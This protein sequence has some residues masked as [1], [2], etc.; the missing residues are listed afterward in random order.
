MASQSAEGAGTDASARTPPPG[1]SVQQLQAAQAAQTYGWMQYAGAAYTAAYATQQVVLRQQQQ[2][3][4][5]QQ[6]A[7]WPA[8]AVTNYWGQQQV[9]SQWGQQGLSPAATTWGTYNE[10]GVGAWNAGSSPQAGAAAT[11]CMNGFGV[12]N[13]FGTSAPSELPSYP[14][15]KLFSLDV[16]CVAVGTTHLISDRYPCLLALVDGSSKV[17]LRVTI[18]PDRHVFSYLTPLTGMTAEDMENGVSLE[19][20]TDLLRKH[21]PSD[22]VLVGQKPDG[23][24]EWMKLRKGV[25]FGEVID[26]AEVLKGFNQKYGQYN[27][28]SLQHQA[29]ILLDKHTNGAHDPAW[30][31]QVSMELY[32]KAAQATP[33]E[34]EAMRQSLLQKRPAPS[35]AKQH[36]YVMDGVCLAKFMPKNCICGR[37]CG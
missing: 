10:N 7:Q 33:E 30:D 26:L 4:E 9:W 12:N 32:H 31:A 28:H 11:A 6:Q 2:Q 27:Y 13:G 21:L 3:Q 24:I 18:K 36:N 19:E 23:D 25:D 14:R 22:A 20:A 1:F 15:E 8:S 5:S 34:L 17:I 35:V 29:A 16:E 37:P